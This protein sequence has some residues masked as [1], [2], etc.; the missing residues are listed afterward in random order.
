M[1]HTEDTYVGRGDTHTFM[2]CTSDC[3]NRGSPLAYVDVVARLQRNL[4]VKIVLYC[5]TCESVC[6][7]CAVLYYMYMPVNNHEI[8]Q[9]SSTEQ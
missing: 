9:F 6:E 3:V 8:Q 4:S 7:N 1:G 2:I 5:T